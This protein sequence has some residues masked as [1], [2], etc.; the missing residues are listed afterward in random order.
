MAHNTLGNYHNAIFNMMRQ[1]Y[2]ITDLENL[3]PYELD[4]HKILLRD[5]LK[6]KE[7]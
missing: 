5:Y 3:Y 1:G 4:I 6:N 7:K 2:T